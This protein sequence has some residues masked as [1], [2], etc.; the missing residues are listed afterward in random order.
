MIRSAA[1]RLVRKP[2]VPFCFSLCP[3]LRWGRR[4]T[5]LQSAFGKEGRQLKVTWHQARWDFQGECHRL[6]LLFS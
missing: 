5:A 4:G 2:H 3:W 6:S 1:T